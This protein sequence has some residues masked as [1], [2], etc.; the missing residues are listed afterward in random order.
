MAEN[1]V[2]LLTVLVLRQYGRSCWRDVRRQFASP[3]HC[4][5]IPGRAGLSQ[6]TILCII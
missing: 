6:M 3:L 2:F 1:A 5:C 4:P